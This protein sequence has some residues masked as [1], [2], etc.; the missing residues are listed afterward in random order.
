MVGQAHA[1]AA[2]TPILAGH[3]L[4]LKDYLGRLPEEGESPLAR[5]GRTHFARWVVIPELVYEGPP[6]RPDSLKAQ[7]LL[8]T[9]C[10]DGPDLTGYLTT[11][12][13]RLG[14]TAQAVWGHCA[15]YRGA[16]DLERYLTHNRIDTG[17]FFAA[18]P[19]ATVERVLADVDRRSRVLSFVLAHQGAD[20]A[21]LLDD[22]RRAFPSGGSAPG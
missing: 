6:Q 16:G 10:F 18:Y 7:Y 1:F 9:C 3:E 5:V 2:L 13:E 22:W 12:D 11:L 21:T 15:G 19:Q 8:F 17:L 20:D 14:G 4:E